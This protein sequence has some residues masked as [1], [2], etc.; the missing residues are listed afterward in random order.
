MERLIIRQLCVPD[1]RRGLFDALYAKEGKTRIVSGE[2][3]FATSITTIP[4]TPPWLVRGRNMFFVRRRFSWQLASIEHPNP[5]DVIVYEWNPR[6][7]SFWKD[8]LFC[9]WRRIPMIVW[10]HAWGRRGADGFF[11]QLRLW[12]ARRSDGVICYTESQADIVRRVLRRIPVSAAPNACLARVECGVS[13]EEAKR[14]AIIYVGRIV[15]EKKIEL[16]I[17]GFA[18]ACHAATMFEAR[19]LIVGDGPERPRLEA[20]AA[21]LGVVGRVSWLG[22]QSDVAVLRAA[23]AQ[24]FV[25]VSPGYVGLSLTQ[26]FGFGVPALIA[27]DEPHSPEIE[28]AREGVNAR[29]FASDD[30]VDLT[31]KLLGAW[32]EW[33]GIEGQRRELAA[34]TAESYSFEKMADRFIEICRR[35][36]DHMEAGVI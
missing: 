5:G 25:S 35:V 8:W 11:Y 30:A 24:A 33:R 32:K 21:D 13:G 4:D 2:Q 3:H 16:L 12:M 20:L 6:I 10:G 19:L 22:H 18:A 9:R 31:A 7:L 27:K 15:R 36:S 14:D 17:R 34:W 26:S 29:F 1:Y 23:Y 28:A